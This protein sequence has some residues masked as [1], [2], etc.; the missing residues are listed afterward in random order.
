MNDAALLSPHATKAL[1]YLIAVSYLLL[2]IPFWRFVQNAPAPARSFRFSWFLAPDDVHLHS[3][4]AWARALAGNVTVGLDDFAHRLIGPIDGLKL[5][6][7][8]AYVRQGQPAFTVMAGDTPIEVLSPVDGHV[9]AVNEAARAH[10]RDTV[11]DP[12]GTGWIMKVEPRWLTANLKNLFSGES[13]RRFLDTAA[14]KL[15]ARLTPQLGM[16][17]QDGGTPVHG[18]AREIDPEHWDEVVKQALG[19][20]A[21]KGE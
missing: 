14:E 5:P 21:P 18:I 9:V 8:G 13:A 15:A 12:Y 11:A 10:P 1:E 19:G 20:D 7:V 17:L 16:A 4:H 3:G 6:E 2:F